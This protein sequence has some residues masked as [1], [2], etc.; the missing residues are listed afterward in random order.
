[1]D[2]PR[3]GARV[4]PGR[5]RRSTRRVAPTPRIARRAAPGGADLR[6]SPLGGRRAP[7]RP[8]H[9]ETRASVPQAGLGRWEAERGDDLARATLRRGDRAL[10]RRPA[11][12]DPAPGRVPGG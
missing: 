9:R 8:L 12:S 3:A 6:G 1:A 7:A 5:L 4:E 2:R 10:A 11:R